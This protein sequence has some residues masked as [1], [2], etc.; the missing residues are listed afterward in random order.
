MY[1]G[2]SVARMEDRRFLTGRGRYVDDIPMAGAR[3]AA[4]LRS[5]HA[6][7]AIRSI[8]TGDEVRRGAGGGGIVVAYCDGGGDCVFH[9]VGA[10]GRSARARASARRDRTGGGAVL[11]GTLSAYIIVGAALFSLGG[12]LLALGLA[13][14]FRNPH[15]RLG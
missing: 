8:D 3:H 2:K 4:F 1:V 9:E 11:M 7:A 15:T 14:R 6:N 5:P 10:G 12:S 13:R